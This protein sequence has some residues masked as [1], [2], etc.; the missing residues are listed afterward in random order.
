MVINY[1]GLPGRK[2]SKTETK[3]LER[4]SKIP[5]QNIRT[6]KRSE[7]GFGDENDG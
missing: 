2:I 5:N 4:Q 7:K 6:A 1:F 3:R